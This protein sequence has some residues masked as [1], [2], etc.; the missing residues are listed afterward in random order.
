MRKKAFFLLALLLGFSTA[1]SDV[2]YQDHYNFGKFNSFSTVR[3]PVSLSFVAGEKSLNEVSRVELDKK[4]VQKRMLK[5]INSNL[6][7]VLFQALSRAKS[8]SDVKVSR[9]KEKGRKAEKKVEVYFNFNSHELEE[10][11]K[12]KLEEVIRELKGRDYQAVVYGY[13]D[14]VGSEKYNLELSQ[15]R[16]KAVAEFL[17]SR[18]IKVKEVKGKGELNESDVNCLN[19]KVEVIFTER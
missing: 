4:A 18:G 6:Q 3:Y 11:E 15:K 12:R 8:K 1:H 7:T 9:G 2:I 10:S 13:A 16:A 17:K 19:R 5:Q 14:C